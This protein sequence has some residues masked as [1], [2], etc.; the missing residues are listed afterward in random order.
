[1]SSFEEEEYAICMKCGG[2]C[3]IGAHTPL[4]GEQRRVIEEMLGTDHCFEY[5]GY[6]RLKC[7]EDGRCILLDQGRCRVNS[8]KPETCLA[9]PF[10]FGVRDGVI[11]IF[12][13][14]KSICPLVA[15][16]ESNRKAYEEQFA[17]AVRSI[18][19]LVSRLSDAEIG[20]INT[21]D[22]PETEKVA[23]IPHPAREME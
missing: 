22:E 10:T 21:I 7:Y 6:M 20:V 18:R 13:K 1:M 8:H 4:T 5:A 16:L 17:L 9:G 2:A 19:R 12:L 11:D 15:Y 14:K 3:C 23:E